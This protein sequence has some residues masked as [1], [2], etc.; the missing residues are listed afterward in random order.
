[1]L[2]YIY[3]GRSPNLK[4]MAT[5]LLGAA[6]RFALIGLKDM[7]EQVSKLLFLFFKILKIFL[8]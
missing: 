2:F 7:A 5:D 6:D 4:E 1:M 8:F 3:S